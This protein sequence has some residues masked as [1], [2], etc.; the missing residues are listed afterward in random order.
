MSPEYVVHDLFST[1][2]DV[3]SFGVILLE[4]VSGRKSTTFCQSD[5]SLNLLGYVSDHIRLCS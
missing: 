3:L 5:I 2:S 1:K 4:I